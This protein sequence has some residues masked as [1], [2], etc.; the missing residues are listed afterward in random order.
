MRLRDRLERIEHL[1]SRPKRFG[2]HEPCIIRIRG[3]L[4][5]VEPLRAAIGSLNL[6]CQPNETEDDFKDRA[7]NLATEK[8]AAFVILGGMSAAPRARGGCGL[9]VPSCPTVSR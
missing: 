6:E 2:G 5:G 9:S 8:G 1:L 3:G 7:V 4:D